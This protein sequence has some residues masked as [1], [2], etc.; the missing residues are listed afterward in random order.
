MRRPTTFVALVCLTLIWPLWA[1]TAPL[2]PA[3]FDL[4]HTPP[5]ID[6][7]FS[8]SISLIN[9]PQTEQA[10]PAIQEGFLTYYRGTDSA[11]MSL[12]YVGY[13]QIQGA[14]QEALFVLLTNNGGNSSFIEMLVGH[15]DDSTSTPQLRNAR[16]YGVPSECQGLTAAWSEPNGRIR[17]SL[18][19]NSADVMRAFVAPNAQ[20]P[21]ASRDDRTLKHIFAKRIEPT[22]SSEHASCIASAEYE[23]NPDKLTW[24][25]QSLRFDLDDDSDG[26]TY[27]GL[28]SLVPRMKA[29]K[30]AIFLPAELNKIRAFLQN[31]IHRPQ[32]FPQDDSASSPSYVAFVNELKSTI[33]SRNLDKL[34]SLTHPDVMLGLGG[35]GGH[36]DLKMLFGGPESADEYW[37]ILKEVIELGSVRSA[38][39]AFCAPY[40]SCLDIAS[41]SA[42][43]YGTLVITQPNIALYE[44]ASAQSTKLKGL[45]YDVVELIEPYPTEEDTFARVRLYDGNTGYIDRRAVRSPLDFRMEITKHNDQWQIKSFFGGD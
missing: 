39:D 3:C 26:N 14:E 37:Q 42:N 35:S 32:L 40:V 29:S 27:A 28:T 30:V 22:L 9:C 24:A 33:Q 13:Q 7:F 41:I 43:V 25:L 6:G 34:V 18:N 20:L 23:L 16:V 2:H 45:N 12:G 10:P 15:L 8:K 4:N 31:H 19:L 44:R 36:D 5:D 17:I 38:K 21:K 1:A 11:G